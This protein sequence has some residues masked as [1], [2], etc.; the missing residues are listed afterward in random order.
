MKATATAGV[1]A[2]DQPFRTHLAGV[3]AAKQAANPRFSLRAFALQLGLEHAT[4]SQLLRGKRP[5]TAAQI[6]RIGAKLGMDVSAYLP[7]PTR[8]PLPLV[9]HPG[10]P[11]LHSSHQAW[12]PGAILELTT[13]SWFRPDTCWIAATLAV[14]P[15]E[16]NV[17][18]QQ[19]LRSGQLVMRARD[20]W[21]DATQPGTVALDP[22]D[23]ARLAAHAAACRAIA[24]VPAD[25]R[26]QAQAQELGGQVIVPPQVLPDGDEMA[27]LV[28]PDGVPF[29]VMK[30]H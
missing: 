29:G 28:D 30:Q 22:P 10:D 1:F 8:A 17:A 13:L 12:L 3:F 21:E 24:R 18:L 2:D 25:H 7:K 19:L 9:A 6:T 20:R 4:L 15:D 23:D 5:F 14:A 11:E 26:P 27:I 16:V